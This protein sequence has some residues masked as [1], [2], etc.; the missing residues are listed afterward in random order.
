MLA[1]AGIAEPR[2]GGTKLPLN[3]DEA[4][5][6]DGTGPDP[7]ILPDEAKQTSPTRNTLVIHLDRVASL[8]REIKAA[9]A[10]ESKVSE[11][12]AK[13]NQFIEVRAHPAPAR[14][15]LTHGL[16]Q[17]LPDFLRLDGESENAE[18]VRA[19]VARHPQ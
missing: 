12:S 14:L 9:Q 3:I 8:M 13:C 5:L 11:L 7:F 15:P 6:P 16:W 4:E 10:A 2:S 19:I 17:D 18:R 1:D